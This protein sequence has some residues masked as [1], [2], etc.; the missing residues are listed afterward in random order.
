MI[1]YDYYHYGLMHVDIMMAG[2]LQC[3]KF[4]TIMRR[5]DLLISTVHEVSHVKF[6]ACI[7]SR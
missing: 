7:F 1:V 5:H 3:T 4:L 6:A 2:Q